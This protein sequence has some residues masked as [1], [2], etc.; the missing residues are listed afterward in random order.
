MLTGDKRDAYCPN[1]GTEVLETYDV[2]SLEFTALDCNNPECRVKL[3]SPE[4]EG[5]AP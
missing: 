1:C 2:S 5:E 3:F 4:G